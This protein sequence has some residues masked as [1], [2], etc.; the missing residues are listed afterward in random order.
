MD[1]K[2]IQVL[3]DHYK[4][5]CIE[6]NRVISEARKLIH[7]SFKNNDQGNLG[8][9]LQAFDNLSM[10]P[11]VVQALV[12]DWQTE[13]EAVVK[14]AADVEELN[15]RAKTKAISSLTSSI[16]GKASIP[17]SGSHAAA[18]RNLLWKELDQMIS[19]LDRCLS[20][21]RI[22]LDTLQKKRSSLSGSTSLADQLR[23]YVLKNITI[24]EER[25]CCAAIVLVLYTDEVNRDKEP[26]KPPPWLLCI[27][28]PFFQQG[29]P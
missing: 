14:V 20:Q 3:E 2:G 16:P 9:A 12:S 25:D 24:S 26:G 13:I 29:I 4:T 22:L 15:K 10:L 27:F 8:I 5:L 17:A 28:P 18:F 19:V 1:W 11:K 21:V 7:S 6:K 23:N